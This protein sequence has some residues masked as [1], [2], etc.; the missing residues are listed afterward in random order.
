MNIFFYYRHNTVIRN[1]IVIT[2]KRKVDILPDLKKLNSPD[3][4][5]KD[6]MIKNHRNFGAEI[7]IERPE[8]NGESN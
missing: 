5:P 2:S 1:P 3:T 7:R 4:K 8:F 6:F